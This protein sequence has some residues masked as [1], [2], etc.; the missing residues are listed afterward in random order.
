[1]LRQW[2]GPGKERFEHHVGDGRCHALG[3]QPVQGRTAGPAG[4]EGQPSGH[5]NPQLSMV[6][7]RREPAEQDIMVSARQVGHGFE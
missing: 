5:R 6:R 4:Y 1:M 7:G 2:P 3:N